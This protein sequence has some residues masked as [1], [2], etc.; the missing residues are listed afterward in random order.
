MRKIYSTV[1]LLTTLFASVLANNK[2]TSN[3]NISYE[4]MGGIYYAY[5]YDSTAPNTPPPAGYQPF[6]ISHFGRHGSRWLP[7]DSRYEWVLNQLSDTTNLTSLGL[8]V[9]QRMLKIW[10]DAQGRGGALTALGAQQHAEIAERMY[11][12]WPEVFANGAAVT[13]HSSVVVRC[14]MSMNA[15]LL[16]MQ[17]LNPTLNVT[18]E[19]YQRFMP[20]IAHSSTEQ[21]AL[22]E[23]TPR[24]IHTS[25]NRLMTSLYKD[26]SKVEEPLNLLSELHCIA[27]DMQNVNIGVSLYDI[28]TPEEMRAVYDASNLNMWTCNSSN[29]ASGDIPAKSAI[30]LWEN[31]VESA[32]AA[33][34]NGAPA[35]TLRFGHDT[36][37]YRLFT[38]L[39]LLNEERRMDKII[40][41][42]AN[43]IL[44]F[45][46]NDDDKVLVK[47][48][49]NEQEMMLPIESND[50]PYYNW[51]AVKGMV[52]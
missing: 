22:I 44:A 46:R 18:A 36:S 5:H 43:L 10:D 11:D 31:F 24:I 21:D 32:D 4:Q 30:S 3:D 2:G 16:K 40:P 27:S 8:D 25:P 42:G 45:Y 14:V 48:M 20:Y 13:A 15:F 12:R 47:F 51:D 1:L 23:R 6:Y 34:V 9:R 28:F 17:S 49:H 38:L 19:S 39:G 52:H 26:P 29:P 50:A 33:I 41:M 35:A 37:L 7:A